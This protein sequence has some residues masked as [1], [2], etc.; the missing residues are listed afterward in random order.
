MPIRD[1]W[2]AMEELVEAGM[3]KNI[4]VSNFNC[5]G[6][7]DLFTYAKIKPSVLQVSFVGYYEV[8]Y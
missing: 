1:T 6:I 3:V 5:Q 7:R 4:G 2:R 8:L